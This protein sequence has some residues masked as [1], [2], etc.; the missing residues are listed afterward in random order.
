MSDDCP[1][2]LVVGGYLFVFV[3]SSGM[4]LYML[5]FSSLLAL[6]VG[7]MG[8][9]IILAFILMLVYSAYKIYKSLFPACWL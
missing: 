4:L 6:Q 9:V 2:F 1:S 8:Y 5:F 7:P 3:I